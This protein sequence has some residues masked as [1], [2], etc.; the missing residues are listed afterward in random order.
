MLRPLTF[1]IFC[2][3]LV[4]F[5]LPATAQLYNPSD[6]QATNQ[7]R[8]LYYSMQR[9]VGAGTIFGH[10]DDTAYGVGWCFV[11]EQS[12]VKSVT[13]SYP[14]L[15]GWDLAKIEHDSIRDINGIPFK[16]Q[17]QLVKEAYRRGGINTFCWHMDNP[18]NGKTAWDTSMRTVKELLPGGTAHATYLQ[19]LDKA[20]AYLNELRGD[21]G[22]L[23]P[24][25]FR[26][27]HELTG[28][29]FWWGANT[30]APDEFKQLWRFTIDYLR[31]T[32]K[33]HQL[34]VVFSEADFNS[35]AEFMQRY[36]GS[37]YVDFLGFDN[38]CYKNVDDYKRNLDKRLAIIDT[39]AAREHK[40]AC[41]PETG[42]EQIPQANWWTTVLLPIL[43]RHKASYVMA[44]RNGRP[45]HY[46]VP[47]PGQVSEADF[48]RFFNSGA[49][50]FEN[51]LAPLGVYGRY[52][53]RK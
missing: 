35:E 53:L 6:G 37:A 5:T 12:D 40:L 4:A 20:A 7:T 3:L 21:D 36:P 24:I 17:K 27:F 10:H 43:Q 47:Y 29:W 13:G 45:D 39:I 9:L 44:W 50:I 8:Q 15:Y 26:P 2:L 52:V 11:K 22:E 1:N 16:Y 38:Y 33:L 30:C 48:V 19:W 23:I 51:R 32:K 34:L 14:A 46:Y 18:A 31:Q 49:V 42:Y 28:N 41:L 25:L